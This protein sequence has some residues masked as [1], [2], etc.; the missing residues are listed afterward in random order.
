MQFGNEPIPHITIVIFDDFDLDS[1]F[2]FDVLHEVG[3]IKGS[4]F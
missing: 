3:E 4:R 1:D 2:D